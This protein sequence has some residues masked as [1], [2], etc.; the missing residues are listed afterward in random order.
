MD[1]LLH[2]LSEPDNI[3]VAAMIPL[4]IAALAW[5]VA[6][7]RRSRPQPRPGRP[8]KVHT[9]PYLVRVEF[10]AAAFV[11]V[12]LIAW[13]LLV[14][15]PLEQPADPMLTP[16]PAKA[17]WYFLGLQEL[18]VY[19]DPWIAG[20]VIP[21]LIVLGLALIPYLDVNEKGAGWFNLA[22]RPF[23]V[24]VFLFGFFV[25]GLGL[26]VVGVFLR[27][28]GWNFFW[29]WQYWDHTKVV[30]ITNVNLPEALGVKGDPWRSVL[31]GFFVT[32]WFSLAPISY[33]FLRKRPAVRKLGPARYL[34][35]SIIL[36]AMLA[37]PLKVL[38]RLFFNIK[39][40]WVTP[41]F[42]I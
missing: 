14:D 5:A 19:F 7:A 25:L 21:G 15:A 11:L 34:I 1:N 2:I 10:L 36:L 31:G 6:K 33:I 9:W 28:P 18:L 41:W 29:P 35:V 8:E 26:M 39:Y 4:F 12:A 42:N 13:S 32:G 20:V 30:A 3:P 38:L 37:V 23:A 27:G 16:N 40:I 22:Q 17:P 24:A